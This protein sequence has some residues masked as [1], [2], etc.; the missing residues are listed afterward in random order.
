MAFQLEVSIIPLTSN[1]FS[2]MWVMRAGSVNNSDLHV[3]KMLP[4]VPVPSL[5]PLLQQPALMTMAVVNVTS[6][7]GLRNRTGFQHWSYFNNNRGLI[8][9][10]YDTF[11]CRIFEPI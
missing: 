1:P 6:R 3:D 2:V 7:F 11:L 5:Q 10:S 4:T 8:M 9:S